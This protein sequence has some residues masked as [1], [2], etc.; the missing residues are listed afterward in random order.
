MLLS[1]PHPRPISKVNLNLVFDQLSKSGCPVALPIKLCVL[2]VA[3][4]GIASCN[5]GESATKNNSVVMPSTPRAAESG[6]TAKPNRPCLDLNS[7]SAEEL[8]RLPGVG[9]IMAKKIIDYRER[10]GRIR[11]PE[12]I[13]IIDGFSERKYRAIA[14]MICVES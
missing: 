12:E 10:Q 2:I 14:D 3:L 13:I 9:E 4:I 11:R 8:I 6:A 1:R 5:S 7:A